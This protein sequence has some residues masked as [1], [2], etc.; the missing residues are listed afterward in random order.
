MKS[1]IKKIVY[2]NPFA[3]WRKVAVVALW[4]L[5]V[6]IFMALGC[7]KLKN[8]TFEFEECIIPSMGDNQS[9]GYPPLALDCSVTSFLDGVSRYSKCS[10]TYLIKGIALD[11]FEYGR[12]IKLVE[13]LK[14]NFPKNVGT[15]I[16]WGN[17]QPGITLERETNLSVCVDNQDVLILHLI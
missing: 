12:N 2:K 9:F 5:F 15:F 8:N 1:I 7:R 16:A 17:G 11:A 14:G 13:D 10:N 3:G 4:V 6:L